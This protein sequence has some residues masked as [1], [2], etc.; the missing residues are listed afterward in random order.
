LDRTVVEIERLPGRYGQ[1]SEDEGQAQ[2]V[3]LATAEELRKMPLAQRAAAMASAI[4][5]QTKDLP[6]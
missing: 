5:K 3:K 1:G 2:L 4:N 6:D